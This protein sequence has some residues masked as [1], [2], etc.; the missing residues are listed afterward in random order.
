MSR[1]ATVTFFTV[2]IGTG[3]GVYYIHYSQKLERQVRSISLSSIFIT[4]TCKQLY[5]NEVRKLLKNP[6]KNLKESVQSALILRES[7]AVKDKE[8][9]LH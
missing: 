2:L 1:Q 5:L 3:A 4:D 6:S 7:E 8:W 9:Y